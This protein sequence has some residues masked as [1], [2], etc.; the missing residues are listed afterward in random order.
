MLRKR[1]AVAATV[2][3]GAAGVGV[4]VAAGD[5]PARGGHSHPCHLQHACPSDHHTYPW[6][7][8]ALYCTSYANERLANDTVTVVYD[9][10]T[11]WCHGANTSPPPTTT[12]TPP[13]VTTTA[14]TTT[15]SATPPPVSTA[16]SAC[17]KE[18]WTVKTLQDRPTL[19]PVKDTTIAYLVSRPAPGSLPD[20]RLPFERRV[21]RV[22]AAVVRVRPEDD[23]DLHVVLSDGTR[24]MISE[25]PSP[26]C[27]AKAT[28]AYRTQ[29]AQSRQ[30]VRLCARAV[31]TGVAFFDFKHGQTGVAPNAIE[32]HPVLGF[33]CLA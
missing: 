23:S 20:T 22:K 2:V 7:P 8:E 29:M 5:V 3:L 16:Q 32:L 25:S 27:T 31:V 19:L 9:G 24:T 4:G 11:Y 21:F 13:P 30:Q 6:G 15:P 18:R 33:R 12:P 26:S 1:T 28:P 10:R 14:V 17:G